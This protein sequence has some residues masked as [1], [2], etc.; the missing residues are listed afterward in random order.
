M[1]IV[2]DWDPFNTP[3]SIRKVQLNEIIQQ[4]ERRR[5]GRVRMRVPVE[6]RGTAQDESMFEESMYT[7]V[8]GAHGAMVWAS[9][10]LQMGTEVVLTNRF[11]QQTARFRV[12]W[13][14]EQ[15]AD[16]LWEIGIESLVPL[17]DFW[18]VR[19]P[20]KPDQRV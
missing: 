20:P 14:G 7:G 18:G 6:V 1:I 10:S 3:S 11:S 4:Y 15:R 2:L 8:V 19:F 12:V 17:D 5:G 13:V 9:R 16:G